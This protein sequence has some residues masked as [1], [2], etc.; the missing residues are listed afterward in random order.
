MGRGRQRCRDSDEGEAGCSSSSS[1][2]LIRKT[3]WRLT[4]ERCGKGQGRCRLAHDWVC[5]G[6]AKKRTRPSHPTRNAGPL[7][8][9]QRFSLTSAL[10]V[11][12][13][14]HSINA[15]ISLVV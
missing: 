11:V 8:L 3:K 10:P 6:V 5:F 14:M 12:L 1:S 15:L 4:G 13:S 2:I 7:A 9:L